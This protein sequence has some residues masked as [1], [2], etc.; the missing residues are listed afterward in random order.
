MIRQ[1]ALW[2]PAGVLFLWATLLAADLETR[3]VTVGGRIILG[4]SFSVHV[5]QE[6]RDHRHA[7]GG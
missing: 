3:G 1:I 4:V 6:V 5:W 7:R 2:S